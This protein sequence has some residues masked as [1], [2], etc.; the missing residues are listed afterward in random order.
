PAVPTDYVQFT[1]HGENFDKLNNAILRF[2]I[3]QDSGSYG[4]S[5]SATVQNA[6]RLTGRC[7]FPLECWTLNEDTYSLSGT[8]SVNGFNEYPFSVSLPATDMPTITSVETTTPD[9]LSDPITFTILGESFDKFS[10][11]SIELSFRTNTGTLYFTAAVESATQITATRS[12]PTHYWT[13]EGENYR[14]SGTFSVNGIG[15]YPIN[16]SIPVSSLP[17]VTSSEAIAPSFRGG[18]IEFRFHGQNLDKFQDVR[19]LGSF[20]TSGALPVVTPTM[21]TA[22]A[23]PNLNQWIS[24]SDGYV[25]SLT[26]ELFLDGERTSYPFTV[27]VPFEEVVPRV[28]K[29]TFNKTL[30]S[31]GGVVD[32]AVSGENLEKALSSITLSAYSNSYAASIT[33]QDIKLDGDTI[34]MKLPIP[35]NISGKDITYQLNLRLGSQ[36]IVL[37][38]SILTVKATSDD[39]PSNLFDLNK[40][41][42][43]DVMDLMYLLKYITGNLK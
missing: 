9:T 30:S 34:R 35:V 38:N 23:T 19:I 26:V 32:V 21:I 13:L 41:G 18:A 6:T 29:V 3:K 33:A 14:L 2:K 31:E 39:T 1:V 8:V 11:G 10:S 24:G 16:L 43:V 27:T 20:P 25:C 42:S 15:N 4:Y 28:T 40:D 17:K 36:Y 12:F 37:P 7:A 22:Y 5:T